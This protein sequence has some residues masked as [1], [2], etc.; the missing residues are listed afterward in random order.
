MTSLANRFTGRSL[1]VN[2]LLALLVGALASL[3]LA[4]FDLWPLLFISYTALVILLDDVIL[5]RSTR[6]QRLWGGFALG[7]C[8][9]FGYFVPS[10]WWISEAFWVEPEKFAALIPFAVAGLPSY[11]SLY[12]GIGCALAAIAWASGP[13]RIISLAALLGI[14]EW[15]RGHLLTG[16]P[17]N[18]PAYGISSIEGF[19]QIASVTGVYGLTVLV[20]MIAASPAMFIGART[21]QVA[22]PYNL[23][24]PGLVVALALS[25]QGWGQWRVGQY[26]QYA[27]DQK[28]SDLIV[29]IVQPNISQK[30]KWDR[31]KAQLIID[32]YLNSTAAPFSMPF[33]RPP[34]IVWPESALPR[35]LAE[36]DVLRAE[37]AANLPE[38]SRLLTGGLHRTINATGEPAIFNSLLAM[39]P[40]G[41][42]EDRHDKVRLV[43]FGEFLPFSW[44]L[45]PLGLRQIVNLPPG[46]VG[47][48]E[49]RVVELPGIPAFAGYICYEAV[50]PATTPFHVRPEL[51]V[52]VTNDAWFGTSGGP[53]QH[54]SHARFRSIEQGAPMIR[55][56][57]TGISAMI[58]S[59]GRVQSSLPLGQKGTLDTVLPVGMTA[60]FFSIYGDIGF[61]LTLALMILFHLIC[62][63]IKHL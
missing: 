25:M 32:S 20:I 47:G 48:E 18:L 12:W 8:F 27:R 31:T 38:G 42:I 33:T 40:K 30:D 53:Y 49:A 28:P 24:M 36:E 14:S 13:S 44:L 17:W 37:I 23:V 41:L 21:R 1:W 61:L 11:L 63:R 51:L 35:L 50:F 29:T 19:S 26:E 2:C 57:N 56:A 54:L 55:A 60:T 5:L 58:D 62:R 10:L 6:P 9:A 52:N 43:P 22:R 46:F 59:V 16:F 15:M 7:W 39:S 45:E 3:S 4:P 34:L